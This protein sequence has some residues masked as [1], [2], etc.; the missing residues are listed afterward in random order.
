MKT[1]REIP[2]FVKIWQKYRTHCMKTWVGFIVVGDINSPK[3]NIFIL[4]TVTCTSEIHA[5]GIVAFALQQW[6]RERTEMLRCTHIA[7]L[8]PL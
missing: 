2:T 6:L 1:C 7:L 3:I 4:L 8:V 5:E